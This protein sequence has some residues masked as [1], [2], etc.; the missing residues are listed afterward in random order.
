MYQYKM[1]QIPEN[2][3]LSGHKK[4]TGK[5]KEHFV[6]EYMQEIANEQAQSGWEFM[7]ID[8]FETALKVNFFSS[9]FGGKP[10]QKHYSVMTFR[11]K[12]EKDHEVFQPMPVE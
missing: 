8:S 6:A 3:A 11:K 7:R 12:E 5:N 9:L 4:V 2:I 10:R 1:I